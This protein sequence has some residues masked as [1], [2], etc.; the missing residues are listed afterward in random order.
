MA[1]LLCG[2]PGVGKTLTAESIAE[3]IR[4]PLYTLSASELGSY[5][6][7]LETSLNRAL[8]RC[9]LWKAVLLI[10]E[11][12]VFME[13]RHVD[14][15]HRNSLVSVF[16]RLLEYYEGIMFLTTNRAR[17]LD[18]AFESRLDLIMPYAELDRAARRDIWT[19]FIGRLGAGEHAIGDA[20]F[21]GLANVE[22]NGRE[23]KSTVKTALVL[24][25]HEGG[26][27]SR[28]HVQTV[29]GLRQK[30]SKYLKE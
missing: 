4:A 1:F 2:P 8:K 18:P 7:V 16:L 21:D 20:D 13:Q 19:N 10:D 3:Q 26:V 14:S 22:L 23:I 12:D 25:R 24:A 28:E 29:L 27:L 5:P 11:A 6:S 15:I 30:A 9:A 17:A